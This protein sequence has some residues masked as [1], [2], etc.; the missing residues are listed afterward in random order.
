[1]GILNLYEEK[2]AYMPYSFFILNTEDRNSC[3]IIKESQQQQL[4]DAYIK[5]YYG[6]WLD[7]K[8]SEK[9]TIRI[10]THRDLK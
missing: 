4:N 10:I 5:G 8:L 6:Q 1:M 9:T 3:H 2:L 7:M